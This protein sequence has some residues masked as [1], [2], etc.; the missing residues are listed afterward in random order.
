MSEKEPSSSL[1]AQLLAAQVGAEMPL[2][3][4]LLTELG[5]ALEPAVAWVEGQ[6]EV[7]ETLPL[8]L[9]VRRAADF[10]AQCSEGLMVQSLYLREERLLKEAE[11]MIAVR[12]TPYPIK[13]TLLLDKAE[14]VTERW[15]KAEKE[16]LA[17][18]AGW[19]LAKVRRHLIPQF[20]S[21]EL[22]ELTRYSQ[23]QVKQTI[24][25][26]FR[27]TLLD[28]SHHDGC[29]LRCD[30]EALLAVLTA[31]QAGHL[32]EVPGYERWSQRRGELLFESEEL[33][34]LATLRQQL[35]EDGSGQVVKMKPLEKALGLSK[36]ARQ[37]RTDKLI[38]KGLVVWDKRKY[39]HRLLIRPLLVDAI[40]RA[41]E[42][43]IAVQVSVEGTAG[44]QNHD[45]GDRLRL[46]ESDL[47]FPQV[48]WQE[49][50]AEVTDILELGEAA[51]P[52]I[53]AV[54]VAEWQYQ[55]VR[56][57]SQG[58][59]F[60][61]LLPKVE[62]EFSGADRLGIL[63][64]LGFG[65]QEITPVTEFETSF[66][67][68]QQGIVTL[69]AVIR[70]MEA[71]QGRL[72]FREL[73]TEAK[74]RLVTLLLGEPITAQEVEAMNLGFQEI[75]KLLFALVYPEPI[76]DGE[77][78]VP[79]EPMKQRFPNVG[80]RTA[81]GLNVRLLALIT[82]VM[83]KEVRLVTQQSA[84][85]PK[86]FMEPETVYNFHR[87]LSQKK[88]PWDV[89]IH[90]GLAC[91][92]QH[93]EQLSPAGALVASI[94][95]NSQV[96]NRVKALERGERAAIKTVAEYVLAVVRQTLRQQDLDEKVREYLEDCQTTLQP[97][98]ER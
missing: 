93:H 32:L 81:E 89:L 22:A 75:A 24:F 31:S 66:R 73:A 47:A 94:Y 48:S 80:G 88:I 90:L 54:M 34:A 29:R 39:E 28:I 23:D 1:A 43:A 36:E 25:D 35:T 20:T 49:A 51:L 58:P 10:L 30:P 12:T 40:V 3:E 63:E 86:D 14:E 64:F 84:A 38:E 4:P 87:S 74:A 2:P 11:A 13:V 76:P 82:R 55:V 26:R 61:G 57:G 78:A 97:L 18:I 92:P 7:W 59:V 19:S 53:D 45:F 46:E 17:W 68:G 65:P 44:R 52:L 5:G 60:R 6:G 77:P 41:N 50:G 98:A 27:G 9:Q 15:D 71:E 69:A 16:V 33:M 8:H 79:Q 85:I 42:R 96:R 72:D 21:K 67:D 83:E 62:A 95:L 37:T 56:G 91:K 70:R